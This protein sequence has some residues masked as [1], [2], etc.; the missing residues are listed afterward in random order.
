MNNG[1]YD[2]AIHTTQHAQSESE[3]DWELSPIVSVPFELSSDLR[4]DALD[5]ET[6]KWILQHGD[7]TMSGGPHPALQFGQRYSF[8]REIR[9][10][11]G[12]FRWDEDSRLMRCIALSRLVHPTS[13]SFRYA[14]H[15]N[16]GPNSHAIEIFQADLR[17]VSIDTFIAEPIARD[18]LTEPE[19]A[20]LG[21]LIAMLDKRRLPERVTRALWY[22]EY[23]ARTYYLEVR[24]PVVATALEALIHT[25]RRHT[26]YQFVARTS[27]LAKHLG[28][29]GFSESLAS[30]AY[31]HR[32]QISHGQ[33][34]E[35][36]SDELRGVYGAMETTLRNALLRAIED[37]NFR[38]TFSTDDSIRQNWKI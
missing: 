8:I 16:A 13:I 7:P 33:K 9:H 2:V 24:W 4:I 27:A 28:V 6:A 21:Q 31:D 32:S 17:G 30:Q 20:K 11:V 34:L 23:A 29:S 19:A 5:S 18:W 37:E 36:L 10:Q 14:A 12:P 38:E 35:D 1:S 26:T 3:D 15:V 25:D 22:H